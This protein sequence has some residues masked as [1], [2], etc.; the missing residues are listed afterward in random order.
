MQFHGLKRKILRY[1]IC[2]LNRQKTNKFCNLEQF[3][4]RKCKKR[5]LKFLI[6]CR[7][8][9]ISCKI[10]DTSP[11][12]ACCVNCRQLQTFVCMRICH[13]HCD[14]WRFQFSRIYSFYNSFC[15]VSHRFRRSTWLT[16]AKT[17]KLSSKERY[18]NKLVLL[19]E[20][21][22]KEMKTSKESDCS[23]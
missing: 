15:P 2:I 6:F 9:H 16:N 5:I 20:N 19:Y 23:Y 3:V 11:N 12:V 21:K 17:D 22:F 18:D 14:K 8:C 10:Y 1:H 7:S 13:I 4:K